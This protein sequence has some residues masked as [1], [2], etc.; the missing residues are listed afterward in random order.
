MF[1]IIHNDLVFKV[2]LIIRKNSDYR[3]LEFVRR[4][5]IKLEGLPIWIVSPEDLIIS[6]LDWA[7]DH[8]SEMQIRDVRNLLQSQENL[9]IDYIKKWV[10]T[11]NLSN[12]YEKAV[13]H[14]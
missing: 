2:D 4:N 7:K 3:K 1:N 5:Q 13:H 8:L 11:L 10:E 14:A 9:D 6:K 12:V